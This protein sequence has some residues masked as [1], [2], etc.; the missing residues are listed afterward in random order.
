MSIKFK[1]QD[2][3]K[4][5]SGKSKGG[6]GAILKVYPKEERVIIEGLNRAKRHTKP[7]RQNEKGGIIE[8]EMPIHISNIMLISPKSN[9]PVKVV[10]RTLDN[11]KRARVEKKTG[12][13]ID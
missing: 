12:N 6:E 9:E 10:R 7:N 5:I 3:V 4:V 13:A 1:K 8:K 2:R 11:G